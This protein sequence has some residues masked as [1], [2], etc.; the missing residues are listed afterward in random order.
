[1]VGGAPKCGDIDENESMGGRGADIVSGGGLQGLEPF[2]CNVLNWYEI[3][4][5]V[6]R[7]S[8]IAKFRREEVFSLFSYS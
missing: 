8:M 3:L 1:M 6:Q 5:C 7:G 2:I 4:K